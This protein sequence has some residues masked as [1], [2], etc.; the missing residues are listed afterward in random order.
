MTTYSESLSQCAEILVGFFEKKESATLSKLLMEHYTGFSLTEI[1]VR[2]SENI[3]DSVHLN[4]LKGCERLTQGEPVQ[5]IMGYAWFGDLKIKVGPGVLI[6]RPE[7]EELAGLGTAFLKKQPYVSFIDLCCGSGCIGISILKSLKNSCSGIFY[8]LSDQALAFTRENLVAL[9][10][11]ASVEKYDV[12]SCELPN[13]NQKV[14][15]LISN[16]PYIPLRDKP[17]ISIQVLKEPELALFVPN[18][19]PL[20]FYNEIGEK[21]KVLLKPGGA[22][23]VE[24]YSDFAEIIA[25]IYKGMGFKETTVIKDFLGKNRFVTCFNSQPRG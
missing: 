14:D 9:G 6:P 15:L 11:E 16:P 23:M 21:A 10:L 25:T 7:T 2:F 1:L 17:S 24:C 8:D 20:L 19:D 4:F 5:Y 22:L 12:L 13:I 18:E 3:P